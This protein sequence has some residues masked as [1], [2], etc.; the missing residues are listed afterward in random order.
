MP[1]TQE[2]YREDKVKL[3]TRNH[4]NKHQIR[5]NPGRQQ[6]R[7]ERLVRI[8]CALL[9]ILDVHFRWS[10]R[11][12]NHSLKLGIDIR[13]RQIHLLN[14]SMFAI[15][16]LRL[17]RGERISLVGTLGSPR[18]I[19]PIGKS[20]DIEDIGEGRHEQEVLSEGGEHVPGIEVQEGGDEV[21]TECCDDGDEDDA[22]AVGG[23]ELGEIVN[24]VCD[25]VAAKGATEK[26]EGEDDEVELD[27]GE[28]HEGHDVGD[29]G[30]LGSVTEREN[31]LQN[32]E[33]QVDI[34]EAGI[35]VWRVVQTEWPALLRR[36]WIRVRWGIDVV[37]GAADQVHDNRGSKPERCQHEPG[38]NQH[39]QIV[40][41]LDTEEELADGVVSRLEEA[42]KMHHGVTTGS[43]RT[44]QP[45][46]TLRDELW[47]IFRHIGFALRGLDVRQ[48]PL[49][50]GFCDQFEAENTILGQEHVL[51][52][53]TH[54]FD[55][56]LAENLR[57]CVISVE[58]LFERPAH[59][60][61]VS[62][63]R[64]G[65]W[66]H[67]DVS[68]RRFQR[69]VQ[70][71][72]DLV[73]E[74]LTSDERVDQIAPA[75][76]KHSMNLTTSATQ[77]LVVIE[78]FPKRKQRLGTRLSTSIKQDTHFWV[79]NAAKGS[80]EPSVR[81][82]LLRIAL[83]QAEHHLYWWERACAIVE[84]ADELLIWRDR[85]LSCVLELGSLLVLLRWPRFVRNHT[86]CAV[87]SFPSI[88]LF[89]IPSW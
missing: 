30:A 81:V 60:S 33:C 32:D 21:E 85:E 17:R 44:V 24:A 37:N 45:T 15:I 72:T 75:S 69:L 63:G 54:A 43:E 58:V 35:D 56:L 19:V 55:T 22:Y 78:A 7:P 2:T 42:A 36:L 52:E 82:D 88:S 34:L 31:E 71:V 10:K 59:D 16:L 8:I 40:E 64:E 5:E 41:S 50:T 68:E 83:L 76:S 18:D 67:G 87:V 13:L 25:G 26:V 79:Q 39:A 14:N 70:D 57:E 80:E 38:Q 51:L 6:L 1:D 49:G 66:Q 77:I 74:V 23:E 29:S 47:R 73:L 86:I 89:M 84:R 62:V 61:A 27:D 65:T 11:P 9:R 20:V 3:L 4:N 46:S 28:D 53:D 12:L 48:M